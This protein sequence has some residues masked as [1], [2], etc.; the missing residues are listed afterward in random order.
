LAAASASR[1]HQQGV[2]PLLGMEE[3]KWMLRGRR[4]QLL[5]RKNI[6]CA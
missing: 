4:T 5:R 3:Q 1:A 2:P 6:Y